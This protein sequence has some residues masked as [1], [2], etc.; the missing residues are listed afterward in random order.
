M[1]TRAMEDALQ[2]I[3]AH[4][5]RG[6]IL[7]SILLALRDMGSEAGTL[8]PSDL[9]PVDE[10]HVGGLEATIE[11][12]NRASLKPGNRVLDVGCGLG[13][14]VRYLASERQCR[15][16]GIDITGEYIE[17]ANS[18]TQLLGLHE[19]AAFRQSS[20]LNM[21]FDD[22]SFD[23]VWTEAAQM[24]IADKRA[25]YGEIARVLSPGGRLAFHDIFQ[26]EGGDLYYPVPWAEERSISFL[27]TPETVREILEDLQF[28]VLDWEDKSRQSL[29]WLGA[30]V[31][32]LK[33]AGPARPGLHLLMGSSAR[34]K[35]D[36][37]IRNLAEGRFVVIQA[38]AEKA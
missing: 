9:A 17:V 11:L 7:S 35:L 37:N 32:R 29:R 30:V 1:G 26:G 3:E 25:F 28:N 24:N 12:A 33:A 38:V 22:G 2:A 21:P 8:A 15:A 36:N 6:G 19:V 27:A 34:T 10:F 23:I 13:G 31:E 16:I 14:S 4:Y 18:L 5:S 20:A